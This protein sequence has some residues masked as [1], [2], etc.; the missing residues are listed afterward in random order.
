MAGGRTPGPL[1]RN[2][3]GLYLRDLQDLQDLNDGTLFRGLSPK[4]GPLGFIPKA[5]QVNLISNSAHPSD[6]DLW[7]PHMRAA[8]NPV[9]VSPIEIYKLLQQLWEAGDLIDLQEVLQKVNVVLFGSQCFAAGVIVG[10]GDDIL[11]SVVDLLKLC[12]TLLLADLHDLNN[13]KNVDT[14]DVI[15]WLRKLDPTIPARKVAAKLA[16]ELFPD[17]LR[18]AAEERGA[19]IKEITEALQNPQELLVGMAKGV[20]ESCQKDWE[21]FWTH[22]KAGTLEGL[23]EAGKIFGKV[24]IAVVGCITGIYGAVKLGLKLATKIP[25]LLKYA[26][27]FATKFKGRLPG[28]SGKV[29]TTQSPTTPAPTARPPAPEAK[30]PARPPRVRD[31]REI[32]MHPSARLGEVSSKELQNV[33][34]KYPN[35]T[36]ESEQK[37][38]AL[39]ERQPNTRSIVAGEE[40]CEELL[41]VPKGGNMVDMVKTEKSGLRVP[42][43]VKSGNTIDLDK[44]K[45]NVFVKFE[46]IAEHTNMNQIS[47]FEVIARTDSEL[48]VNYRINKEGSLEKLISGTADWERVKFGGK[49][50]IVRKGPIGDK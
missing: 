50:V 37:A 39:V 30:R 36:L 17:E 16:E 25:Q 32:P 47:H 8:A 28:S 6:V 31:D 26:R 12:K 45:N 4:P 20:L 34:R 11:N 38:I 19:L 46:N 5:N 24:L 44:D 14:D 2:Q 13:G 23:Y 21:A 35:I 18:K 43:E 9:I 27:E 42:I 10:I 3:N 1:G 15:S 48:P 29:V 22:I 7:L 49:E 40:N 33:R 41:G